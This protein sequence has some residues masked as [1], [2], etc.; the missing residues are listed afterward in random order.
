MIGALVPIV[1]GAGAFYLWTAAAHG[2][3]GLAPVPRPI[4]VTPASDVGR[5]LAADALGRPPL[6]ELLGGMALVAMTA[7]GSVYAAFGATVPAL[8]TAALAALAPPA[9]LRRRQHERRAAAQ[10]AWPRMLEELRVLTGSA[11]LSIPR[12]LFTVGERAPAELGH[13]FR[14]ARREWAA[15]TDFARALEVL[16]EGLADPGAD[17]AAETLLVAHGL[18]GT[19]LDGRLADLIA[20]RITDVQAR[21]DAA[22]RLAGARF[23]RRFV[24]LVPVGM[25]LVGLSI[26]NGRAAYTTESGQ[27]LMTVA[28]AVVAACWLWAGRIMQ[29]PRPERVFGA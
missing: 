19:D 29:L 6:S 13:A 4:G 15:S 7:G 1:A 11:G 10:E 27:L 2:W 9:A 21:R 17:A 26:G 22:A 14:A 28:V 3:D 12:A 23:A 18:G 20:D 16:K 24:I 5:A 8:L 25:G